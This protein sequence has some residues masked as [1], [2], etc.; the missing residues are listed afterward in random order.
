MDKSIIYPIFISC[1]Q[2]TEDKF[3]KTLFENL[4]YGVCPFGTYINNEK[5]Y[6]HNKKAVYNFSDKDG[7]SVYQGIKKICKD[8]SLCKTKIRENI[9][10]FYKELDKKIDTSPKHFWLIKK[11]SVRDTTIQNFLIQQKK[12]YNLTDYQIKKAYSF[13]NIGFILKLI[14]KEDI[15]CD[16]NCNITEIRN[17]YFDVNKIKL[18]FD[19]FNDFVEES[20]YKVKHKKKYLSEL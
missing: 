18:E 19:I 11:K 10:S 3:W 16:D 5:L 9:V 6:T 7:K 2:Y 14:R 13:I 4:A 1:L 15:K 8:N 17:I 20:N 12:N